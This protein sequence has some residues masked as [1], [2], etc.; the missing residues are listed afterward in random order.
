MLL[1]TFSDID[2]LF[3]LAKHCVFKRP[4]P[5]HEGE[6]ST[7][8]SIIAS[9]S[10]CKDLCYITKTCRGFTYV[11]SRNKCMQH[12]CPFS[13]KDG[14]SSSIYV[15]K[16]CGYSACQY[17]EIG[18]NKG[19][20]KTQINN[21]EKCISVCDGDDSC[22]GFELGSGSA[23]SEST[24]CTN[25]NSSVTELSGLGSRA[26]YKK[27]CPGIT[28][29]PC[30]WT[31]HGN[32]TIGD[33]LFYDVIYGTLESCLAVCDS[34]EWCMGISYSVELHMS[35]LFPC[36]NS[37]RQ[38]ETMQF[39]SISCPGKFLVERFVMQ[40]MSSDASNLESTTT[41]DDFL[42]ESEVMTS[43]STTQTVKTTGSK[44]KDSFSIPVSTTTASAT[45]ITYN[46]TVLCLCKCLKSSDETYP[47]FYSRI[48][49]PLK[50][51]KKQLSSYIRKR[52][53]AN[54]DRKSAA[55]FGYGGIFVLVTAIVI[56]VLA[57]FSVLCKKINKLLKKASM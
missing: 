19:A 49:K 7:G 57:D 39:Y 15:R 38:D 34:E 22:Q 35:Y 29:N 16:L 4:Q 8:T 9:Q 54:D 11:T 42:I 36:N 32:G 18:G 14:G 2:I 23:A 21:L 37:V 28:D 41:H 26:L 12:D 50:I 3:F 10:V 45:H 24:V 56:I 46:N 27:E 31:S 40:I 30:K 33:C 47:Q 51:D 48:I 52:N 43:L 44:T 17:V 20:S 6:C 13:E 53:S 55:Y 1:N 25:H 5:G